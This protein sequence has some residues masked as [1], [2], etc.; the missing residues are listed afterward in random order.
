MLSVKAT[1]LG[2]K[3]VTS[4]P[5]LFGVLPCTALLVK[6]EVPCVAWPQCVICNVP[7]PDQWAVVAAGNMLG[8]KALAVQT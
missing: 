4:D 5:V 6:R 8:G 3:M 2:Q 1:H 7:S